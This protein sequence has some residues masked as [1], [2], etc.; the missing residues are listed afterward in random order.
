MK[1]KWPAFL[2]DQLP[3][4]KAL[5]VA[6]NVYPASNGYRP[7]K[8][9]S[10]ISAAL[11]STFMGGAAFVSTGG[12]AFLLAG[13]T[14]G[15]QRYTAGAWATLLDDLTVSQRWRFTQF[16]NYVVAVNGGDTQQVDLSS[17]EASTIADAPTGNDVAVVGDYV[18][19]TQAD[20]NILQV[21]WSAF[22]D[23][24][25]WT[26]AVDQ[27]G[28]QPMLTGGEIKGIAG[29]EYG[30]ILQRLRLVRMERTGDATSPFNFP[31]ITPNFG[32]ASSGSIAQAGRTVFFLSDRGFMAL[33]DG[34]TLRP[35]GNEKFDRAFRDYVS[36]SDYERMWSA[37][38]PKNSIVMWGVAGS[39]GRIWVYNWVLDRA[40]TID[41][42]FGGFFAGYESSETLEE[43]AETY[44]DIDTMPYSLDDPRF[45]GGDP[46]VYF[47]SMDNEV[48][49]LSGP[50]LAATL[51]MGWTAP[52]DPNVFRCRA[53][54]PESDARGD[55]SVSIDCR[56]RM[57]D[58]QDVTV[59]AELQPSGRVPLRCRGKYLRISLTHAAGSMWSYNQGF[60]LEGS[61]GG[62]R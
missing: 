14:T 20:G 8:S 18:V 6:S 44:D 21:Q 1:Y 29:G 59:S 3:R 2:P 50:L 5:T 60:D 10:A 22:N 45:Q 39:P 47:V 26:P 28:F 35:I 42:P 40:S 41:M 32:C 31:E 30:V 17:A 57:G 37:V 62:S 15:L 19:I 48:G 55:V 24:T 58:L 46:R 34:T 43:V 53:L 23:H 52:A 7:V 9:F 33:D 54:W 36:P 51:T 49:A 11:A 12:T 25:G 4:D 16:G 38:D 56:Q 27:S 13:T 61:A